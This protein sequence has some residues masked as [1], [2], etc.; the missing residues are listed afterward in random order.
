MG[1]HRDTLI[2]WRKRFSDISDALK[3]GRENADYEVE[4]ELFE[5]CKTRTVTVKKPFKLK[6][7]K[8]DGKKRLEEER[9]EYAEE[10]VVV[11]A[12]VTAQIFYLKN[13]QPD[14]WK[15]RPMESIA[16]NQKDNMQTVEDDPITKSLKEEFKK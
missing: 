12:N 1:V 16:E 2:E 13:R 8:V 9:I 14:K 15:D 6:T 5:S 3:R 7:V 11:P 4:N 10:Q